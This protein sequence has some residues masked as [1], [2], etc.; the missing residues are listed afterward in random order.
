MKLFEIIKKRIGNGTKTQITEENGFLHN[1]SHPLFIVAL[2]C[3]T[4]IFSFTSTIAKMLQSSSMEIVRVYQTVRLNIE[5]L[6]TVRQNVHCEFH[7]IFVESEAMGEKCR[8]IIKPKRRCGM[9]TNRDHYEGA[10]ENYFRNFIFILYLDHLIAQME[11]RCDQVNKSAVPVLTLVPSNVDLL[12]LDIEKDFGN[13]L[14]EVYNFS[15]EIRSWKRFQTECNSKPSRLT[16]TFS[17]IDENIF[18]II[19]KVTK[20]LMLIPAT[21]AAVEK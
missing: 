19:S 1:I 10:P 11:G 8:T 12:L 18:P 17:E 15:Y 7:K 2:N 4:F 3:A 6:Q 5:E 21:S 13:D 9:Q 14:D 20:L 16:G